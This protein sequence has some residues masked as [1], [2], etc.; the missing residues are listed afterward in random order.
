MEAAAEPGARGWLGG[1]SPRPGSPTSSPELGAGSRSRSGPGSGPGSGPERSGARTPGPAAPS[2]S[3]RKVTLT[4]PTFCHLCSDFIWGLAG[5]LCDGERPRPHRG[6]QPLL[7]ALPAGASPGQSPLP[8]GQELA[9]PRPPCGGYEDQLLAGSGGVK[10]PRPL[11][12]TMRERT[13]PWASSAGLEPGEG[14][15]RQPRRAGAVP[16]DEASQPWAGARASSVARQVWPGPLAPQGC[17]WSALSWVCAAAHRAAQVQTPREL[18][19]ACHPEC[20]VPRQGPSPAAKRAWSGGEALHPPAPGRL[21]HASQQ[22]T[23]RGGAP[24]PC[25]GR[26]ACGSGDR[27]AWGLVC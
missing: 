7:S 4:K 14:R 9:R 10:R 3:F 23:G 19:Q 5:I 8:S 16:G 2:H 15:A 22:G 17:C 6:P 21:T 26:Q 1:G 13:A 18:G 12:R 11:P 24:L 20:D 25:P 27:G